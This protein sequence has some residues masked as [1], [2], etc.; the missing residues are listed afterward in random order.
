MTAQHTRAGASSRAVPRTGSRPASGSAQRAGTPAAT[1]GSRPVPRAGSRSTVGNTALAP[2]PTSPAPS[3]AARRRPVLSVVPSVAS[4]AP[5]T[6]FVLLILVLV[7]A[8]LVGL[9]LLNTAINEN[10]FRLHDL[11]K[12]N[13][14]LDLREQQLDRDIERLEAP[15]NL[16]A[17]A[18]R[19]GLVPAGNPAYIYLP[20]G[21]VVGVPTPGRAAAPPPSAAPKKSAPPAATKPGT[22]TSGAT[23]RGTAKPG[24]AQSGAA[25]S[26]STRAGTTGPGAAQPGTA[27]QGA[28]D[29]PAQQSGTSG[30]GR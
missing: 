28:A 17:A 8:G 13:E 6:P 24:A 26:G 20:S 11:Q 2:R 3:G 15:G 5:R 22:T 12:E 27:R 7:A 29:P 25:Q 1:R 14:A 18:R 23:Q 10:V 19:L 4:P 21:Q 30:T 9:L 16:Q